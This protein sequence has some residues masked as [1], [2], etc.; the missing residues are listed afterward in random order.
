MSAATRSLFFVIVLAAFIDVVW[1]SAWT[2]HRERSSKVGATVILTFLY[3]ALVTVMFSRESESFRLTVLAALR[4]QKFF[5]FLFF[6]AGTIATVLSTKGAPLI[7]GY[8]QVRKVEQLA[9]REKFQAA[10]GWL[11]YRTESEES[12]KRL[13]DL[14]ARFRTSLGVPGKLF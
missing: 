2:H 6:V 12:S 13:H 9:I 10:R 3:F 7:K 5:Y 11:D 1:R 8:L 14:V 4:S